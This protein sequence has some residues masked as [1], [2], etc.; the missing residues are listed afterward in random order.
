MGRMYLRAQSALIQ[1]QLREAEGRGAIRRTVSSA[2][3]T[4]LKFWAYFSRYKT[5]GN[6]SS[7]LCLSEIIRFEE[8]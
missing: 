4:F 3:H 5:G 1:V 6:A 7:M 2:K 8:I